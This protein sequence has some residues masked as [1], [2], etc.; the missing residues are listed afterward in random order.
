V[1]TDR[2]LLSAA[3]ISAADQSSYAASI[4]YDAET[5]EE[6]GK[7]ATDGAIAVEVL[8]NKA[9]QMK[10]SFDFLFQGTNLSEGELLSTDGSLAVLDV[11]QMTAEDDEVLS[12]ALNT[13]LNNTLGL[14]F[15]VPGIAALVSLEAQ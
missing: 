5:R 2:A 12:E 10:L 8:Q 3:F 7:P 4:L 11:T 14:L 13:L 15:Q 6:N 9:S 1:A